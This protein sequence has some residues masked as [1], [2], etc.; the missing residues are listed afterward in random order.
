MNRIFFFDTETT[1]FPIYKEPSGGENQPHI[2]QIAVG[3]VD[4]DTRRVITSTSLI[5]KPDGWSIPE[6]VTQ[7]HGITNE[8]AHDVGVPERLLVEMAYQLWLTAHLRVA[9]VRQFDDR[10]MRIALK[11]FGYGDEI[12]DAFKAGPGE[13]TAQLSRPICEVAPSEAQ[14]KY[15]SFKTKTP[16]LAE[17]YEF[18]TG[19]PLDGAHSAVADLKGC[20]AVYW[21]IQDRLAAGSLAGEPA[22]A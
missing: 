17:A 6:E 19:Q 2:V 20:M 10:I 18:F 15:T 8:H 22:F 16:T 12:A 11:R 14:R 13:C 4:A 3:V 9:H 5:A 1:G 7:I 21:A